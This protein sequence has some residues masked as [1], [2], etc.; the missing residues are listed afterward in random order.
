[1]EILEPEPAILILETRNFATH[2]DFSF[3]IKNEQN[4]WT[5]RIWTSTWYIV[6]YSKKWHAKHDLSKLCFF[7]RNLYYQGKKF[8]SVCTHFLSGDSLLPSEHVDVL[9]S[10]LFFKLR[11]KLRIS[12]QK[13]DSNSQKNRNFKKVSLLSNDHNAMTCPLFFSRHNRLFFLPY[14]T[15]VNSFKIKSSK[16]QNFPPFPLWICFVL[17]DKEIQWKTWWKFDG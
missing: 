16:F 6:S 5:T 10:S 13:L 1:M 4:A 9:K 15:S 17:W 3:E 7:R 8:L 11:K 2:S 12:G 14:F